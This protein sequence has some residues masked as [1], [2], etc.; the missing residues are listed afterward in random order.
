MKELTQVELKAVAGGA[1]EYEAAPLSSTP[2]A[3]AGYGGQTV[4][5]GGGDFVLP[6]HTYD[7]NDGY[8][9]KTFPPVEE[10]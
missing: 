9:P 3:A 2:N 4:V 5:V 7:P 8:R 6:P 1:S 10:R